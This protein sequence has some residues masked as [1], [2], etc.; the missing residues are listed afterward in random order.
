MNSLNTLGNRQVTSLNADLAKMESG[1]AGPG[2]Q[3]KSTR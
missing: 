2:I 3:G 1:E